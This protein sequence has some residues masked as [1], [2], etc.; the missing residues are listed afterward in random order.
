MTTT[1]K[2]IK[3]GVDVGSVALTIDIGKLVQTLVDLGLKVKSNKEKCDELIDHV[4]Q[5]AVFNQ[6]L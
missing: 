3:I 1:K 2:I 5:V 6:M 4:K